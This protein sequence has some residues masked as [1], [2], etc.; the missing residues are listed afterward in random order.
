MGIFGSTP[1]QQPFLLKRKKNRI[2]VGRR[3]PAL[4]KFISRP[5]SLAG[6]NFKSFSCFHIVNLLL[7]VQIRWGSGYSV[8]ERR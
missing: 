1:D 2:G 5:F 6:P 8:K 4:T 7:H 3:I